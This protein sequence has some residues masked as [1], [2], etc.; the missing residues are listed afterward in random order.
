M[1]DDLKVSRRLKALA[2][3]LEKNIEKMSGERMGFALL[4]FGTEP[5]AK[6]QYISNCDRDQMRAAIKSLVA[7]WEAGLP[8]IP[9]HEKQ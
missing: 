5:G 8:D 9:E 6:M 3:N 1:T 2:K 4:V 7:G